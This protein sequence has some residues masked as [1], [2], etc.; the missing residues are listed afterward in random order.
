MAGGMHGS[1]GMYGSGMYGNG[2]GMNGQPGAPPGAVDAHLSQ[3]AL[4][5]LLRGR[6]RRSVPVT[7]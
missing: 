5:L 6:S 7:G 1:G 2:M 4:F 3:R